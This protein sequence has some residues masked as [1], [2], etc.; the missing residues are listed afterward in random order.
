MRVQ[1]AMALLSDEEII[2]FDEFTFVVDRDV[3]KT[4]CLVINKSIKYNK[5]KQI[6]LILPHF[7]ILNF[8]DTDWIFNTNSMKLQLGKKI[9]KRS[10]KLHQTDRDS[11]RKKWTLDAEREQFQ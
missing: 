6:I 10:L 7:D 11:W 8:L 4:M 2:V 5:N 9:Q 1:L 3:A